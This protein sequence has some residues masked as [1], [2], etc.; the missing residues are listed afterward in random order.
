MWVWGMEVCVGGSLL[1]VLMLSLP[2]HAVPELTTCR[3][4]GVRGCVWM[5]VWGGDVCLGSHGGPCGIDEQVGYTSCAAD[6]W[7]IT[8]RSD[9]HMMWS[10]S[11]GRVVRGLCVQLPPPQA[12]AAPPVCIAA[13]RGWRRGSLTPAE[14]E[15]QAAVVC[16][17]RPR[18]SG[19]GRQYLMRGVCL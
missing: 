12:A 18:S 5:C 4:C 8:V 17:A 14:A 6:A 13:P 19:C 9:L 10:V 3:P 1:R 11:C 15:H 2:V 7:C 16:P